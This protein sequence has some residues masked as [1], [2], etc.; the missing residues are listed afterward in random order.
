MNPVTQKYTYLLSPQYVICFLL[1]YNL[2]LATLN[3]RLA[4]NADLR[5]GKCG[6]I[7]D[8]IARHSHNVV[9]GRGTPTR[10]SISTAPCQVQDSD[11][12]YSR[13]IK[14]KSF[15]YLGFVG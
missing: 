9:L 6:C 12:V 1:V 15:K 10:E 13:V 4:L 3:G 7:V 5:L 11:P 2:K 14:N 8:A